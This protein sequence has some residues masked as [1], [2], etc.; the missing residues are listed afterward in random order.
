MT[1][2]EVSTRQ[3]GNKKNTTPT[4][5]VGLDADFRIKDKGI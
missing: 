2:P 4:W 3:V 1:L 5:K